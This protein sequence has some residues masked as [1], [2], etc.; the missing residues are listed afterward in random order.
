[1]PG[2]R[3]ER[4]RSDAAAR[5]VLRGVAGWRKKIGA[6]TPC[7]PSVERQ[8]SRPAACHRGEEL[9]GGGDVEAA[10]LMIRPPRPH[11]RP[12]GRRRW[13]GRTRARASSSPS[14]AE[15]AT[16]I[17]AVEGAR[18]GSS[19][20]EGAPTRIR[21]GEGA[22]LASSAGEGA[23]P[24][25]RAVEGARLGSQDPVRCGRRR[26]AR[27]PL[28]LRRAELVRLLQAT[29]SRSRVRNGAPPRPCRREQEG[30]GEG[31]AERRLKRRA[32]GGGAAP[33]L[34]PV[35]SPPVRGQADRRSGRGRGRPA[36]R[37]GA[38]GGGRCGWAAG[39]VGVGGDR[40]CDCGL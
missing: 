29:G 24:R 16:T 37:E 26:G 20:G 15:P 6:C 30:R 8:G 12:R 36:Q 25:I 17:R 21:A 4:W 2:D 3:L 10:T 5:E 34:A 31:G 23:P 39:P 27:R 33:A 1:V 32:Y 22:C 14:L 13:G 18:L 28:L 7:S 38:M 9:E 40:K 19:A 11:Q 35:P